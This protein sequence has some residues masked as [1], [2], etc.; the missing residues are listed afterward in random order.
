MDNCVHWP[1][2]SGAVRMDIDGIGTCTSL[3]A[4]M[5]GTFSIIGFAES[6]FLCRQNV[7]RSRYA[8]LSEMILSADDRSM[9]PIT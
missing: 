4:R 9:I 6:I 7:L 2:R 3:S 5:R 1:L 8:F